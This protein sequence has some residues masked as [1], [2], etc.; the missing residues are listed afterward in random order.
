MNERFQ[1]WLEIHFCDVKPTFLTIGFGR[2]FFNIPLQAIQ[3]TSSWLHTAGEALI[4][5]ITFSSLRLLTPPVHCTLCCAYF[6]KAKTKVKNYTLQVFT[7][8][9]WCKIIIERLN[10]VQL[11]R[12]KVFNRGSA[13][14]GG[15]GGGCLST[16]EDQKMIDSLDNNN[17]ITIITVIWYKL[18]S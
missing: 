10:V 4:L 7:C 1:I 9:H 8:Q 18:A 5:Q 6:I 15:V 2:F 14:P 13:A 11:Y 16:A 3:P 17:N 12:A